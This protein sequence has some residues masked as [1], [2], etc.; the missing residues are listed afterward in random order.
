MSFVNPA[1]TLN[2]DYTLE[3]RENINPSSAPEYVGMDY[4]GYFNIRPPY[5]SSILN[6]EPDPL[7]GTSELLQK[8]TYPTGGC[9]IFDF[10]A[11]TY[12]YDGSTALTNFDANVS[13][14]DSDTKGETFYTHPFNASTNRRYLFSITEAQDVTF[15]ANIA[16]HSGTNALQYNFIIYG[17]SG[18]STGGFIF[19]ADEN[20]TATEKYYTIH[21][22]PGD[23]EVTFISTVPGSHPDFISSSIN[24][25]YANKNTNNY[26][27]L[28]GGGNR[29]KTI[30]YFKDS[31]I[32]KDY[33]QNY[34]ITPLPEKERHYNYSTFSNSLKSS[35][36]LTYS[37]PK[38]NYDK[39]KKECWY[40]RGYNGV[41]DIP[42]GA[43]IAKDDQGGYHY[44]LFTSFNNLNPIKTQGAD[45][46][47]QNVTVK[48]TGN[49][50][51]EFEYTSPITDPEQIGIKNLSSPFLPTKNI[52]FRRGLLKKER[53][54]D[55][56]SRI[57]TESILDYDIEESV[58]ITGIRTYYNEIDFVNMYNHEYY[59]NYKSYIETCAQHPLFI[60]E[61]G[62]NDYLL[63]DKFNCDC[64]CYYGTPRDF[65]LHSLI[66][67]AF[68]W[69]KLKTKTTKNY[70]YP[71]GS[72]LPNFVETEEK[73]KYN[74]LNKKIRESSIKNSKNELLRTKY[75]YHS[76]DAVTRNRISEIE[77]IE[78]YKDS[79]LLSKSEILYSN[80]FSGNTSYLPNFIKTAKDSQTL[81]N[82]VEYSKYDEYGHPLEVQQADG[83]KVSYIWGYNKSQPIA[84][85][86]NFSLSAFAGT[87]T[88][89]NLLSLSNLDVDN[90][91]TFPCS[92]TEENLRTALNTL[93]T[94]YPYALITT[95]TYD[96]LIGVTSET[97][98]RGNTI[99]YSYNS[100]G[101]LKSVTDADGNKLSEN[102]YHYKN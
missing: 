91:T 100:F 38:F 41:G 54:Y 83:T 58:A 13:N 35:G 68:G 27:Y 42:A 24:V 81:E 30:G 32:P 5:N 57:L 62:C 64:F 33:Y 37:I 16:T 19:G 77:R 53:V 80:G 49:G 97:D 21:L 45:V 75:F 101:R 28:Y 14:W 87:T 71:A 72:S 63:T 26:Q 98:P 4:W 82:R 86:E 88:V 1:E 8:M 61:N 92:G 2:E 25:F 60:S 15:V 70:F 40:C 12:S 84:K 78:T 95:Y 43:V 31:N 48:E 90:C 22:L 46:G 89:A 9:A 102:A 6:K 79:T 76:G 7:F 39:F 18:V 47:Y 29:I 51:T 50:W 17:A 94:T 34:I 52:D 23:Y 99:Y 11:N 56:S 65:T 55:Q 67:E 36:S 74:S 69:A 44:N 59:F 20:D 73:Y 3:Y 85:L 66:E 10:E 93:R 96:P